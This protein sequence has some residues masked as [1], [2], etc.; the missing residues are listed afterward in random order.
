LS[1]GYIFTVPEALISQLAV[2]SVLTVIGTVEYMDR[3]LNYWY[4]DL[5]DLLT[6][7]IAREH[8]NQ[9]GFL[10]MSVDFVIGANHGQGS[11]CAGVKVISCNADWQ[12]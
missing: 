8:I 9:P 4:K 3:T 6:G 11:F 12:Y 1:F 5:V 2:D 10:H 7:K